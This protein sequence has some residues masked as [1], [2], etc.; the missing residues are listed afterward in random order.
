M[1]A[2]LKNKVGLLIV[3]IVF[4][5]PI[6]S[7]SASSGSEVSIS[8]DGSITAKSVKIMQIAGNTFFAKLSWGDSFIRITVKT[9][10]KTKITNVM[11]EMIPVSEMKIDEVFNVKGTIEGGQSLSVVA[12]E[13]ENAS[14]TKKTGVY[15]GKIAKIVGDT[16][17]ILSTKEFGDLNLHVKPNVMVKRGNRIVAPE[18][19]IVG[20]LVSN[21]AGVLNHTTKNLDADS[22]TVYVDMGLYNPRNFQGIL[23]S[24]KNNGNG[25]FELLVNINGYDAVVYTTEKTEVLNVKKGKMKLTRFNEDDNVRFYGARR[26]TD[27]FFIDAEILRNLDL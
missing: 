7:H 5:V 16:D 3:A 10:G 17:F 15:G 14:N 4:F 26:E 23:K 11:G 20:D 6:F 2:F 21:I 1:F 13:V 25:N 18:T 9:N 24:I 8:S 22:I 27:G 12:T 19:L